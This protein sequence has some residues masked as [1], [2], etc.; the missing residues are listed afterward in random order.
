M[1]THVPPDYDKQ[2]E[3]KLFDFAVSYRPFAEMHWALVS[4]HEASKYAWADWNVHVRHNV[5]PT[6]GRRVEKL[7]VSFTTMAMLSRRLRLHFS[8]SWFPTTARPVEFSS[9]ERT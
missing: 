3:D 7:D 8:N 4:D 5:I 9:E 1:A 6:Y 2:Q